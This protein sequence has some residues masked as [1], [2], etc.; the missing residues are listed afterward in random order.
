M[1]KFRNGL[2]LGTYITV[3]G[4]GVVTGSAGG[5]SVQGG[6]VTKDPGPITASAKEAVADPAAPKP[7]LTPEEQSAVDAAEA[8]KTKPAEKAEGDKPAEATTWE[9]RDKTKDVALTPEE[10]AEIAGRAD[11]NDAQKAIMSDATLEMKTTGDLS[12]GSVAKAAAAWGVSEDMVRQ[13]V[14]G[15][16]GNYKAPAPKAAEGEAPKGRTPEQEA[17]HADRLNG[18]YETAGS[19]AQYDA[20]AA[21]AMAGGLTN[22]EI[23]DIVTSTDTSKLAGQRALANYIPRWLEQG[24]GKGPTTLERQAANERP[25]PEGIKGFASRDEQNAALRQ[26]DSTGRSKMETDPAYRQSVEQRMA[27][28]NFTMGSRPGAFM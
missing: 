9:T 19:Q 10:T 11:L 15:I 3:G 27:V 13:Y 23:T 4:D 17:A 26:T 14:A 24:G 7:Q 16:K 21:W 8:L 18:L 5:L 6:T 28:S 2:L 20:F 25:S 1:M 12:P 22:E